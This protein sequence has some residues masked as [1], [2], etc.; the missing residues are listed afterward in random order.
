M[1]KIVLP[2]AAIALAALYKW[3]SETA[4]S[5]DGLRYG[6]SGPPKLD[7]H[8]LKPS[9][10]TVPVRIDNPGRAGV[11]FDR[12]QL[13]A[14][15]GDVAV[16][17]ILVDRRVTVPAGGSTSLPIPFRIDRDLARA[18]HDAWKAR[19]LGKISLVGKVWAAGVAFPV[20]I[21]YTLKQ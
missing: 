9:Y 12:L 10:V 11:W 16:G 13:A 14:K 20:D 1:L 5:V 15:V 4:A 19:S 17:D 6:L 2:A 21:D 3:G 8:L 7:L 18:L